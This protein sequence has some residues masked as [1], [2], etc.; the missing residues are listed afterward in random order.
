MKNVR[1]ISSAGLASNRLTHYFSDGQTFPPH[2]TLLLLSE[3]RLVDNKTEAE[4]IVLS[5]L[6]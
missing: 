1:I 5:A 3:E 6:L 2:K 4:P